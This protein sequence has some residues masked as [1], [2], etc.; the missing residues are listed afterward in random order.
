M[1]G[2]P[3]RCIFAMVA[4]GGA[5]ARL[6]ILIYHR[7]VPRPDP[8]LPDLPHGELFAQQMQLVRRWFNVLPLPEAV[9]RLRSG[10]LPPR[11]LAIT[12]DDGYADNETIALPILRR[13]QLT[14]T[15]FVATGFL[16]GRCMWNDRVIEAIRTCTSTRLDLTKIGLGSF[17]V[18]TLGERRRTI[19]ELLRMIKHRDQAERDDLAAAIAST[20]GCSSAPALM[21]SREQIRSL[22][23]AGM[24]I[25]A[26]T[27]SHPILRVLKPARA[28]EE[29]GRSREE[30]EAIVGEP[31]SLFAYP[32]GRPHRDYTAE[33]VAMARECGFAAAVTT[34]WGVATR[35]ADRYQLPRFTPWDR[36]RWRFAARLARNLCNTNPE[37]V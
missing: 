9:G 24:T 34:A 27:V 26:H 22:H 5:G 10:S 23:R 3:F 25:G 20:A 17:P 32:N 16:E 36:S 15:F 18:R 31:I 7:V 2:D 8:L 19:D 13:L 37:T 33:H 35:H 28:R 1:I 4:P 30:L 6:S 11:A 29:I 21:M 12:F 14:A